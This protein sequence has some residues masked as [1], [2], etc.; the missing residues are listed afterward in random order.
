MDKKIKVAVAGFPSKLAMQVALEVCKSSDMILFNHGLSESDFPNRHDKIACTYMELYNQE[1]RPLF[2]EQIKEADIL[3]DCFTKR[4]PEYV[5]NLAS[6][7]EIEI[8][9]L[10]ITPFNENEDIA[11]ILDDIRLS[12]KN[13]VA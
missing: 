13:K 4:V 9:V 12:F 10:I 6:Y 7:N 1:R 3:V 5:E 11:K 2:F 8:P